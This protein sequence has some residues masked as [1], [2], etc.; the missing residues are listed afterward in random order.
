MCKKYLKGSVKIKLKKL[1]CKYCKYCGKA[2]ETLNPEQVYCSSK[3]SSKY[4]YE[5]F[6]SEKVCPICNSKFT[7]GIS[8]KYCSKA[9]AGK[10]KYVR[11]SVEKICPVCGEKFKS[12]GRKKYCSERCAKR[13]IYYKKKAGKNEQPCWTCKKACGGCSWSKNLTPIE[14]WVALP[15]KIKYGSVPDITYQIIECP[16][17][18]REEER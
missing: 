3:C 2:F 6:K 8:Q 16:E 13:V 9:C 5:R 17:Y 7:G 10:V 1:K 14:G 4:N 11:K 15:V 12:N 18:E